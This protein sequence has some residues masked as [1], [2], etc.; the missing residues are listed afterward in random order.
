MTPTMKT[1]PEPDTKV[2]FVSGPL[3]GTHKRRANRRGVPEACMVDYYVHRNPETGV[4][5]TKWGSY[6]RTV[7]SDG[8]WVFLWMEGVG[9]PPSHQSVMDVVRQNNYFEF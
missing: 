9:E 1:I 8:D 3:E 5:S 2:R 7:T 4:L 6:L